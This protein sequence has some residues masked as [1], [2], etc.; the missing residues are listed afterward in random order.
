MNRRGGM[1]IGQI[2]KLILAVA[3]V[4]VLLTLVVKLF[5][6]IFDRGDETAKSYFETLKN[7]IKVADSGEGGEFF[8]W[9]LGDSEDDKEFY[10]VYFGNTIE[11]DFVKSSERRVY[12]QD[13]KRQEKYIYSQDVQFN[14]FGTKDNRICVCTVDG[15]KSSCV[16]CEALDYPVSYGNKSETWYDESGKRIGIKL[17]GKKYVFE[18]IK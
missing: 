10:L 11:V 13:T 9:Y 3:V 12:D 2:A 1:T 7:E 17:E 16:Y 15:Y 18:E 6:P 14:S 8:M 4:I 5:S